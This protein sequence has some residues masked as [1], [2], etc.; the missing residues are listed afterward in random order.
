MIAEWDHA[1][2]DP[3]LED[4]SIEH[5]FS[6]LPARLE[7][8]LRRRFR[9][10]TWQYMTAASP[11]L[12]VAFVVGTAGFAGNGFVYVVERASGRVHQKF[13]ITPLARGVTLAPSSAA[14]RHRFASNGLVVELSNREAGR[15][16]AARVTA[17]GIA[18]DLAFSSA[19]TD[20]HHAQCVPLAGGRW[21]YTHKFGAFGVTGTVTVGGRTYTLTK[22]SAFG[23]LDFTKMYALR[24]AVWKWIAIAGRT[25]AGRV[26]GVN[27]VDPT[28]EAAH[29]ENAVWIDGKRTPLDDVHIDLGRPEDPTGPWKLG[30]RGLDL[31]MRAITHVEQKL[32]VPLVSHRLRH[33][34]GEFAGRVAIDGETHELEHLVGIAEDNDTWW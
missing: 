25:R 15:A 33:V 21:N 28:P 11:E 30:A 5:L 31:E 1:L 9:H 3:N 14:G 7:A 13:A 12:F 2:A 19:P 6:R 34:V 4:A 24:H 16:F 10:K 20:E 23:T 27:L 32:A 8:P 17:D 26:I 18:V 29:S 22:D